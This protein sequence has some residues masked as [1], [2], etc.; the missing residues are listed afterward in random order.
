MIGTTIGHYRILAKLGEGGMGTVWKAQHTLLSRHVVALKLLPEHLWDSEDACQRFLRGAQAVAGLDH[1]NIATL[2]DA[3]H[4]DGSLFVAFKL[5]DGETVSRR[6]AGGPLPP[7]E[8]V[9]IAADVG[10]ALAHAHGRGVLHRDVSPGNVMI[11]G[12]GRGILLDIGLARASADA[13]MTLTGTTMG[14]LTCIAPEVLGGGL[15]DARTDVYALGV[16]LYRMATGRMP[17][18]GEHREEVRYMILNREPATPSSVSQNVRQSGI[19]RSPVTCSIARPSRQQGARAR[20]VTSEGAVR[21]CPTCSLHRSACLH[22][23]P[24]AEILQ[25]LPEYEAFWP[26]SRAGVTRWV[27]VISW[28]AA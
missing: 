9:G 1:P 28:M 27:P 11:D 5:I 24:G 7:A 2:Y 22:R 10:A 8:A 17:F 6:T 14:T 4:G 18:E 19:W 25:G 26:K 20:G 23:G 13:S 12:E 3:D 15:A 16:V 21:H